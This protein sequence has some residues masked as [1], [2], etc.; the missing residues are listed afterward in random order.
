MT[1]TTLLD[2]GGM[3]I[4]TG[5]YKFFDYFA[6]KDYAKF[7]GRESDIAEVVARITR[8]RTFVLY[9]RSGL[10]KTSLLL[11]GVFPALR[12][13]GFEPLRVRAL[14]NALLDVRNAVAERL[15]LPRT[16]DDRGDLY[17]LLK[18]VASSGPAGIVLVCDQF[19][20]FFIRQRQQPADRR[21]FVQQIGR[22]IDD[23]LLP[24]RV[25]FS[26]REDYIAEMD[27]FRT[28]LPEI[29]GNTYRLLPL[30][31]FG[32]RQA[33]IAPLINAGIKYDQRLVVRL[34]DL[35][36]PDFDPL[37]LQ[38]AC[39]EVYRESVGRQGKGGLA[40]TEADLDALGGLDGLFG[41]YLASA[42]RQLPKG[43]ILLGRAILDALI[44]LEDTKRAVTIDSLMQNDAFNASVDEISLVLRCLENQRLVRMDRRGERDWYELSHERLVKSILDWFR[45]DPD[46]SNFRTARDLIA[47]A[48]R[49]DSF[50]DQLELLLGEGQIKDFI[51]PYRER[52][53]LNE[54]QRE[55]MFWS[56]VY[57]RLDDVEYWARKFDPAKAVDIV[58]KLMSDARVEARLGAAVAAR[59]LG[60]SENLAA[61]CFNVA[62]NDADE[63]VRRSA[64][65]SLAAIGASDT[66]AKIAAALRNRHTRGR[67]LDLLADLYDSAP[68]L[69]GISPYWQQRARF[70]LRR[71]AFALERERV[72]RRTVRGAMAGLIAGLLWTATSGVALVCAFAWVNGISPW[73]TATVFGVLSAGFG[74]VLL[75]PI[76]GVFLGRSAAKRAITRGREG[77]WTLSMLTVVLPLV[78]VTI[79][80]GAIGAFSESLSVMGIAVAV[81]SVAIAAYVVA[82]TAYVSVIRPGAWPARSTGG[83]ALWSVLIGFGPPLLLGLLILWPFRPLIRLSAD[84]MLL[85]TVLW[86]TSGVISFLSTVMI[87]ALVDSSRSMPFHDV[88]PARPRRRWLAR[89]VLVVSSLAVV[90]VY[91]MLFGRDSVPFAAP[92]YAVPSQSPIPIHLKGGQ[93]DSTYFHVQPGGGS[94]WLM[95]DGVPTSLALAAETQEIPGYYSQYFLFVPAGGVTLSARRGPSAP[96]GDLRSALMLRPLPTLGEA[97]TLKLSAKTWAAYVVSLTRQPD[98]ADGNRLWQGD[99]RLRL[100]SG[101]YP[102][103]A[104]VRVGLP[105]QSG[106]GEIGNLRQPPSVHG[107]QDRPRDN[108]YRLTQAAAGFPYT[109][110]LPRTPGE[111][112]DNPFSAISV[113]EL[114]PLPITEDGSAA[115]SLRLTLPPLPKRTVRTGP[116]SRV[117]E[118][119]QDQTIE[120]PVVLAIQGRS[121]QK[122]LLHNLVDSYAKQSGRSE[123]EALERKMLDELLFERGVDLS[124]RGNHT[125]ALLYLRRALELSPDNR[126]YQNSYAWAL[127][128]TGATTEAL[129]YARSAAAGPNVPT[130]ILDTLAHA[131]YENGDW[132]A[133]VAAW[134]TILKQ[135]PRYYSLPSD[136]LC[137]QDLAKFQEAKTKASQNRVKPPATAQSPR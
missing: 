23:P 91:V 103:E 85:A 27:E 44:T 71:R 24:V 134:E 135:T 84:A 12:A 112:P 66:M 86:V 78:V 40:L 99:W 16:D 123:K 56:A 46:F 106:M 74:A 14:G 104:F 4:D 50:R 32:A 63:N 22:V 121:E 10:G 3:P 42:I 97:G 13:R 108:E 88:G 136:P 73:T 29:L 105:A 18:T 122:A 8:D 37:L 28:S 129:P 70:R 76:V 92:L 111:I 49:S 68:H 116:A 132:D 137:A 67:A 69:A 98:D 80:L 41:R 17:E 62:M 87:A 107:L 119:P 43:Y 11:A 130:Y 6:E 100:E 26:L 120:I 58:L 20:E 81:V 2:T 133:A 55:F 102:K 109:T 45:N 36:A 128:A 90:P 64:G 19:E 94:R 57:R 101:T 96:G 126:E 33:I 38:I 95:L 127:I 124:T 131:E 61:A 60:A 77:R 9:G 34:V 93:P 31:A 114:D 52:L 113:G 39:T 7:A 117:P 35:L 110:E 5:P 25:V 59:S 30:T 15:G 115:L 89:T 53:R 125:E 47:N 72:G 1:T 51:T 118:P 83:L 48:T 54:I 65:R 21:A 75:G 82:A 79:L